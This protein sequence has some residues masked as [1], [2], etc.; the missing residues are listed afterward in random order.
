MKDGTAGD[1]H[2]QFDRAERNFVYAVG[3]RFASDESAA[4]DIAQDA[5]LRAYRHRASFR[6]D[7]HPRTWLYRIAVTSALSYVR[8]QRRFAARMD[9]RDPADLADLPGPDDAE[10]PED[11]V[12]VRELGDVLAKGL[13]SLAPKYAT[14]LRLRARELP[15]SEIAS[16]LGVTV[17]NVKVMAHRARAKMRAFTPELV[18]A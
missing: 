15:D 18:A 12:A 16:E 11:A 7:A 5:M 6:G 1:H 8:R 2:L 13:E 4:E 3:R 10:S 14:V 9:S 17:A